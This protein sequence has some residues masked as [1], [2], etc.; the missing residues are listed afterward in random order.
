MNSYVEELCSKLNITYNPEVDKY[1]DRGMQ[2]YSEKG[3][4]IVDKERLIQY[5]NEYKFFRDRWFDDVLKAADEVK[6]DDD[7]IRYLYILIA[8]MEDDGPVASFPTPDRARLDTDY[9]PMF[10]FMYFLDDMIGDM[11]NRGV[12]YQVISDTL[13][14]FE[15][16]INDY[17]DMY[18]RGGM[19]IYVGWFMLFVRGELLRIG[20]LQ[21]QIKKFADKVK[22]YKK[23]DDV[24]LLIDG[25]YVHKKGMLFGSAGQDDEEGKYFADIT[26]D[27]N[28]VK[29]YTVNKYGECIPEAIELIDYSAVVSAGDYVISVHIPSHAPFTREE[30]EASYKAAKE[31]FAN[32]YKEYDFKAFICLSWMMETKLRDIMGR[33]TNI[34]RFADEYIIYPLLSGATGVYSFLFHLSKPC[35]PADLPEDTSMQRAVKDYLVSGNF[36]YEKGGIILL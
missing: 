34:T 15:S 13:N 7:L 31:I 28:I 12:P 26:E 1:Y 27:N 17:Y 23:D 10:A 16:E 21:Y 36:F 29:G 6:K 33:D 24:K 25:Q 32:C 11:K 4:Y 9:A 20:R 19:R 18:G 8:I 5:N 35:S 2:L 3:L 22:V 14:G 30:C